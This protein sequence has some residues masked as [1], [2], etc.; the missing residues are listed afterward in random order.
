MIVDCFPFFNELDLLEIRLNTLS[1]VV[2]HFVLV[3]AEKT[4]SLLRKPLY[5]SMNQERFVKFKDRIVHV[6]IP[7][8]DCPDNNID[9]WQM[10]N[11]QRDQILRGLNKWNLTSDDL[12]LISD[13]DEIPHPD[14]VR[15]I[16]RS[17]IPSVA[18]NMVFHA[19]YLN[20]ISPGKGW[21]GTVA[22]KG[23]CL[24]N[25]T[26]QYFRNIKDRLPRLGGENGWHLSW[27][28]GPD[29]VYSK[30]MSCIE[31]L[32]KGCLPTREEIFTRFEARVKDGGYFNLDDTGNN[33]V[34][35]EECPITQLPEYVQKNLDKFAHLIYD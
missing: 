19:Y 26:P 24:Q 2:D 7:A 34:R 16:Y 14:A 28:G 31:P 25:R 3:E 22:S 4:Q 13:V 1:D 23:H 21:V 10:E 35:L 27:L 11:F 29:K 17:S 20:I 6:V 12:V 9:L 33:S 15:D 32:N 5:Y 30:Y 18:I 8:E